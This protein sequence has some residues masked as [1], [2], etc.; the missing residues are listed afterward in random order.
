MEKELFACDRLWGSVLTIG[1]KEGF[2]FL[3]VSDRYLLSF[4][5]IR[6]AALELQLLSEPF[7]LF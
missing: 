5:V 4:I 2:S 6:P 1:R 3:I 7:V